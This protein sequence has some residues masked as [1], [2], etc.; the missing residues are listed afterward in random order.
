ML[1]LT[2]VFGAR[3]YLAAR[4]SRRV[5]G[6]PETVLSAVGIGGGGLAEGEG[7]QAADGW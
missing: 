2:A 5:G 4:L 7:L 3:S 6:F 1:W